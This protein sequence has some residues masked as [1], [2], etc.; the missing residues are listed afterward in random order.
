MGELP[1]HH[2]AL[3]FLEESPPSHVPM[4]K[5]CFIL[6]RRWQWQIGGKEE[7]LQRVHRLSFFNYTLKKAQQLL[8]F[9]SSPPLQKP[10]SQALWSGFCLHAGSSPCWPDR[11]AV[12]QAGC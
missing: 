6:G 12:G 3:R 2:T 11:S 7:V 8:H 5:A 1:S 9:A 10:A 4:P